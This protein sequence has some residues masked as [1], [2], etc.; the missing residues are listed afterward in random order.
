MHCA[1][2]GQLPVN[3]FGPYQSYYAPYPSM[4]VVQQPNTQLN[5]ETPPGSQSDG[6]GELGN[7]FNTKTFS[8]QET[9]TFKIRQLEA[10]ITDLT[11][12]LK[13]TKN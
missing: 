11:Q 4:F 2:C 8:F 7:P 1:F 10:K 6:T 12:Q 9:M 3:N 5:F 13:G